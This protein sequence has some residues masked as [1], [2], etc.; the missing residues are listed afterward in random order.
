MSA[1]LLDEA[2]HLQ[3]A[4][5]HAS[6]ERAYRDVLKAEPRNFDALYG[7]AFLCGQKGRFGQA[8]ALMAEAIALGWM[9]PICIFCAARR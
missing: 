8:E 4:G 3:R 5:D 7:L 2:M 1:A 6:A 9:M